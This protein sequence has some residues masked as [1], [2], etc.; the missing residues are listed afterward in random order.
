MESKDINSIKLN[1]IISNNTIMN[2]TSKNNELADSNVSYAGI[3]EVMDTTTLIQ[4]SNTT[5]FP[6][7]NSTTPC[8]NEYCVSDDEYVDMVM[9]YIFPSP[10]EW[11]LI[12][13][14]FL[15][16]MVGLVG[17]FLVCFAVWRN[18]TMR[19]VTNYFIGKSLFNLA[20]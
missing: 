14:Y 12:V 9:D 2:L 4:Y 10:F 17:N 20:F 15:V 8:Q 7:W 3:S 1:G 11:F 13:A 6:G 18:H 16:F 5:A 19:T